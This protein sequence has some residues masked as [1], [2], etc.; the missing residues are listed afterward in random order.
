MQRNM[1]TLKST[2]YDINASKYSRLNLAGE[3][4]IFLSFRDIKLLMA[5]YEMI[6]KNMIALDYGCG[7]GR[8]TRYLRHIG[9]SNIIGVDIN[10]SMLKEAISKDKYSE[11]KLIKSSYTGL[12]DES[13]DFILS[14]F[15]LVE[16]SR[17]EEIQ[18]IITEFQRVLR[19]GGHA[20]IV[21]TSGDFYNPKHQWV[22]YDNDYTENIDPKSGDLLRAHCPD[23]DLT[24]SDY[25]WQPRDVVEIIESSGFEVE[26]LHH[27]I[28]CKRDD[29]QW[30]CE[31]FISPYVLYVIR[32]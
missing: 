15:V 5:K 20:I 30:S 18:Q 27:P 9:V 6:R 29:I 17:K 14:S 23:I 16:I 1:Q 12:E 24:F 31:R 3:G 32:K 10:S 28:G 25:Y 4:T 13:V 26:E 22:S 8:S 11:Y 7:A 21:S 2:D 19:D